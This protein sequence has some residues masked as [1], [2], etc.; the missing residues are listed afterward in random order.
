VLGFLI[1]GFIWWNLSPA[2]KIAGSIWLAIGIVYG[3]WKTSWFRTQMSFE[4]V[5]E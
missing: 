1:C 4:V 2:A 5:E 3:A